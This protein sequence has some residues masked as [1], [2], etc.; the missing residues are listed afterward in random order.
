MKFFYLITKSTVGGAQT[1]I[2][3]LSR[4]FIGKGDR[5]AVMSHPGGWLETQINADIK[6]NN[7]DIKQNNAEG[8]FLYSD[9][10]YKIRGAIFSVWKALG[11][12]FKETVYQKA[13]ED[14]FKK[15]GLNFESQKQIDIIYNNKKI[16]VYRPDFVV[17]NKILIELKSL[18]Y[19][20]DL[21][22][23]QL[24]HYLK[25]SNYRLALLVNFGGRKLQIKRW[26]YDKIRDKQFQRNSARYQRNSAYIRFYPN[27]F[28]ANTLNPFKIARA[29][30]EINRALRD[31]KPDLVSCHSTVAGFLGR[32]VIRKKIPTIFTAHGWAFTEGV[33][34]LRKYL[35]ILAEKIAAHWSSRIIC[36]SEFD[37][38]LALRYRIASGDKLVTIHNGVETQKDADIKQNNADIKQ[39]KTQKGADIKQ[40]SADSNFIQR[41]SA[42]YQRKSALIKIVFVGRLDKQKD[43]LLLLEGFNSLSSELKNKSQISIIG[44]G[45][46]R[47]K[48]EDFIKENGLEDKVILLGDLSREEVFEFLRKSD[49]FVLTSNWE[50][51]PRSILEAMSSSLAVIATDVGGVR[52]AV[53]QDCGILIKRAAQKELKEALEKL[54]KN[55]QL[56][57]KM[58]E[59]AQKRVKKE[60]SLDRM[61]RE[62]EGVYRGILGGLTSKINRS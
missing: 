54:L 61:F 3:Q 50:G 36:V 6:Q 37:K 57:R 59:A 1:H 31:F 22:E 21:E 12:A 49:I 43:P 28:L 19:L 8:D 4:Y 18:P 41:D 40:N 39:N 45:P 2:Y 56:I 58:G 46:K 34:I 51:F 48:L 55:P 16:G 26:V 38:K 14:E 15:I 27:V 7:A 33:P 9:I 25:G 23:K 32:L 35:A 17:E 13:L 5:V 52:E 11:S 24:W 30:K 47:K 62:T 10:T 60:F 29:M 44:E 42:W 20:T 53:S